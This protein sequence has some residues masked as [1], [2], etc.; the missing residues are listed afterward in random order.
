MCGEQLPVKEG[1][2][3]AVKAGEAHLKQCSVLQN[4]D[5]FVRSGRAYQLEQQKDTDT[6]SSS[7][8]A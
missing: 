7:T 6:D 1:T 8:A 2:K 5:E 3:A 4:N